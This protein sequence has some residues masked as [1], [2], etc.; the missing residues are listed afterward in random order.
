MTGREM[1]AKPKWWLAIAGLALLLAGAFL[2][3]MIRT[4]DGIA[5]RDIR[6]SG[7]KSAQMSA[8]LYV[9]K[10]ATSATKVPG[11][12]AV[13]GYI[14]SRET[15]DGFAIEF[16]R[17]GYVVLSIDQRG[18][19]YSDGPAFADGFGGPDA[20]AY[21]RSLPMVDTGQI[22]LEGH[23]MGGWTI[24]A[25]ATAMPD[26][27][28]SMVLEGSSTGKPFAEE[29]SPG[30]PRNMALV[31]SKYDEFSKIM[32]DVDRAMDVNNSAKLQAVFGDC[33]F[34]NIEQKEGDADQQD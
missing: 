4:S 18:H 27:Y 1:A 12:L 10:G 13:H 26:S 30:W 7:T 20:L 34:K 28:A 19:G 21:L 32:W 29:G 24:L 25:A 2:A 33:V 22:G 16:A 3:Q 5:I 11:I 23:S 8:L 31:F 9:P 17:R 6:F 15:Q 14:N